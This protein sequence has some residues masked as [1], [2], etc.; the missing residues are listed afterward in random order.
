MLIMIVRVSVEINRIAMIKI[1][2][3]V[4]TNVEIKVHL[5]STKGNRNN[6]IPT[7]NDIDPGPKED[8]LTEEETSVTGVCWLF[9]IFKIFIKVTNSGDFTP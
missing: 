7:R 2:G 4:M 8:R 1:N 5:I 6:K 9:S 3:M